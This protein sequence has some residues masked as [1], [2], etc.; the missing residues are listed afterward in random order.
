VIRTCDTDGCNVLT[1][2]SYCLGCEQKE[3]KDLSRFPRG[4]PFVPPMHDDAEYV[5]GGGVGGSPQLP[6]GAPR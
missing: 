4:R 1:L 5:A 2:G 6:S 3:A